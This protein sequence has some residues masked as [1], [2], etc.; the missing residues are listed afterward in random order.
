MQLTLN[1]SCHYLVIV[2][3]N[4]KVE[5]FGLL[6][7]YQ[8]VSVSILDLE[9]SYPDSELFIVFLSPQANARIVPSA[10]FHIL[11]LITLSFCTILTM[12]MKK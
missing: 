7:H 6:L 5:C 2:E 1:Y 3:P 8:E 11:F 9:A 12:Q 10:S 4:V